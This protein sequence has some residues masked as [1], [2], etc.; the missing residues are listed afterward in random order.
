MGARWVLVAVIGITIF[1]YS[2]RLPLGIFFNATSTL[3][4]LL[5]V[6][7][8]GH[9]VAALQEAGLVGI[10]R[11]DFDSIPLLGIY[12]TAETLLAQAAVIALVGF[13]FWAACRRART[14]RA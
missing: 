4:A 2:I 3:I 14:Q 8:N 5:A 1:K 11:F 13:G 9:G 7:L 12:P 10:T 6:V